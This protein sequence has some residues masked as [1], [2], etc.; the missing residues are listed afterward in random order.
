MN[1]HGTYVCQ[2]Q[3]ERERFRTGMVCLDSNQQ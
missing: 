3:A 2:V 1:A